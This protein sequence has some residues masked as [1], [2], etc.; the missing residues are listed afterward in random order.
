MSPRRPRA[1]KQPGAKQGKKQPRAIVPAPT[2]LDRKPVVSFE[3][4]DFAYVGEWKWPAGEDA[5]RLLALLGEW[6]RCTWQEL[7]AQQYGGKDRHRKHHEQA[8]GSV[9]PAAQE[10]LRELH[11]DEVFEE[12][13]RFR[14]DGKGRVWGFV[15]DDVFYLLWWDPDHRVYPL[16]Q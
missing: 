6:A 2:G 14:F 4:A 16:D 12:F 13:F 1:E 9:C 10:R 15:R 7:R 8:F 3:Y 11:L 5:S